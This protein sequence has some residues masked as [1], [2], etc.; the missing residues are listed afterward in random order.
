[1]TGLAENIEHFRAR[2]L[3]DALTEATAAYWRNRAADFAAVGT[4][5][6]DQ[7]ALACENR[8]RVSL[9]GGD[10]EEFY[11]LLE[12]DEAEPEGRWAS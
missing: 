2:I 12:L 9:L 1:M 10:V 5:E 4:P 7:V 6:C 11:A 3:Q 8:A